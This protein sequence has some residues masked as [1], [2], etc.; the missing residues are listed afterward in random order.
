[1]PSSPPTLTSTLCAR[2]CLPALASAS[3]TT[4][5]AA[6]SIGAG[7]AAGDVE[8]DAGRHRAA[9]GERGQRGGEAALGEHARADA[10]REV[11]QLGER[12]LGL[13]ARLADQL[14]RAL[15]IAL[16][17]LLGHAEV[18]RERDQ[19]RLR[20]VVQVALDALQ[21][22][23]RGVDHAGAGGGQLLHPGRSAASRDGLSSVSDSRSM[24]SV[25]QR[26]STNTT[27]IATSPMSVARNAVP[28]ESTWKSPSSAG[29]GSD[30]YQAGRVSSPSTTPQQH[31]RDLAATKPNVPANVSH[32]RSFQLCGSA[33]VD[34][35]PL[36][37][38]PGRGR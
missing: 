29:S 14:H 36:Q 34:P 35:E 28:I 13:L 12:A 31:H 18:E 16:E 9:R 17:A 2:L 30:Q 20:A 7:H 23:G 38:V 5:Q 10:A 33:D 4:N 37:R 22:G 24:P 25:V 15:G 26:W 1:M 11:A 3:E 21:L 27:G 19:P 8:V 6:F 32:A